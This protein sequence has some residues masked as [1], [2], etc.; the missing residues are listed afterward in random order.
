MLYQLLQNILQAIYK[1]RNCF[2]RKNR[3]RML[4]MLIRRQILTQKFSMYLVV[5]ILRIMILKLSSTNLIALNLRKIWKI[6]KNRNK[7]VSRSRISK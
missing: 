2:H 3:I 6:S 1:G 4:I 7:E 5:L